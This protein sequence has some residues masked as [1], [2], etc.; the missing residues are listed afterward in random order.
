[1]T[2]VLK[3]GCMLQNSLLASSTSRVVQV[4]GATLPFQQ[5]KH[6][7]IFTPAEVHQ[8][9][10]TCSITPSYNVLTTSSS[11]HLSYEEKDQAVVFEDEHTPHAVILPPALSPKVGPE[12]SQLPRVPIQVIVP[13]ISNSAHLN[14]IKQPVI[15]RCVDNVEVQHQKQTSSQLL[16]FLKAKAKNVDVLKDAIIEH[17]RESTCTSD[18]PRLTPPT[19]KTQNYQLKHP[20]RDDVTDTQ[21]PK[22]LSAYIEN[23]APVFKVKKMESNGSLTYTYVTASKTELWDFG[24]ISTEVG[25]GE[26]VASPVENEARRND[27]AHVENSCENIQRQTQPLHSP[28]PEYEGNCAAAK[29]SAING[30]IIP[31]FHFRR[32]EETEVVVSHVVTPGNFYIQQADST[33][34]LQALVTE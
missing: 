21:A 11:C 16:Q 9:E 7:L 4:L 15:W 13:E 32:F 2:N 26:S 1:M 8:N 30:I 33:M 17:S 24:D 19:V 10:T 34:K 22:M 31:E 27:E 29:T 18:S 14:K 12:N 23:Q 6:F 20:V 28:Q 5:L 3:F 25:Q